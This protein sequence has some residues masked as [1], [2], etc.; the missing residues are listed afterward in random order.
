M[1]N[2]FPI[3]FTGFLLGLEHA[4][5]ADHLVAVSTMVVHHK[6]P[7]KAALVGTFWGM[8]HTF[9]LFLVGIAVLLFKVAIPAEIA[10]WF[11]FLVGV[12]LTFLGLRLIIL[13]RK[14][15][16][17]HAHAH[18][19]DKHD[20]PHFHSASKHQHQ[21]HKS[22][23]IG[24]IHGLAGSGVLVIL[25]LSTVRSVVDGLL[26]IL[27]FG[28]GSIAGMSLMS[29]FIGIPFIYSSHKFPVVEKYLKIL[30]GTLGILIGI[31]I[32]YRIGVGEGLLRVK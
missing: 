6:N 24:T 32:M 16:H 2:M 11:E 19:K 29:I 15:L 25:V 1:L 5:E 18:G 9:T 12:M 7:W 8:G 10:L 4:F 31:L 17:T 27:I 23:L 14:V 22:F 26:Y 13:T 21:H 3:L 20:H 28:I 30:A